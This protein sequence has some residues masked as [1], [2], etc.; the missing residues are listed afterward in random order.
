MMMAGLRLKAVRL[1]LGFDRQDTFAA[2]LGCTTTRYNNWETGARFPAP[3][4]MVRILQLFGI[5]PDFIY[6]GS[7]RGIPNDYSDALE[8]KCAELGAVIHAP[9]AE[10]P[11][12]KRPGPARPQGAVP[13]L[14]AKP[15][16]TLHERDKNH[17]N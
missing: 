16:G 7:M 8:Q 11:M 10:W 9:T 14:R 6:G 1:T 5:G 12:T 2:K 13:Q 4:A 3:D 15:G 17:H